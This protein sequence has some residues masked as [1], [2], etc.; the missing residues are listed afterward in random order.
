MATTLYLSNDPSDLS[1]YLKLYVNTRSP[2]ATTAS[3]AVTNTTAGVTTT[4]VASTLTAGGTA[5]KW[6]SAPLTVAVTLALKPLVNLWGLESTASANSLIALQLC[7]YTTSLQSAFLTT[8]IGT[9]LGTTD[10]RVVW[11]SAAG[12]TM[13][14]TAFAVGD[15]IAI[16]PVLGAVGTM[17]GS[18][19]STYSYNGLNGVT[20]D[21]YV[22]VP[23][24]V[25]VKQQVGV[26]TIPAI[27]GVGAGLFRGY[28]AAL[29][30]MNAYGLCGT[31]ATYQM[32]LD[33]MN[34][35][36]ADL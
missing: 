13:T 6:I 3:T 10:A 19:T 30:N 36:L 20:G 33:E 35:Q 17:G 32:L 22:W 15:R 16:V 25:R 9:E 14:S 11:L 21:T 23:E 1:G 7:Q 4:T 8:S 28:A 34:Q 24:D 5:A 12:E 26:S 18:L 27:P 29:A 2:N 31:N